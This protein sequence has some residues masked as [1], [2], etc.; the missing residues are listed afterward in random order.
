MAD[1]KGKTERI[2]CNQ[3]G[4]KTKHLIAATRTQRVSEPYDNEYPVEW[5][6]IYDLCE[7]CGCEEVSLRRRSHCSEWNHGDV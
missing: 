7:C 4:H 2:H 3:C 1:S 5:T 6:T